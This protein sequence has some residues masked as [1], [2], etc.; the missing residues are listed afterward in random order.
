MLSFDGKYKNLQ[1]LSYAFRASTHRFRDINIYKMLTFKKYV[2]VMEYK[3][4][5][6]TIQ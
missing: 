5:N 1:K 6:D 3:F 4:R 2:K